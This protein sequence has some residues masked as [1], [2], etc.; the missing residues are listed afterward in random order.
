MEK[1]LRNSFYILFLGWFCSS[2]NN[3]LIGQ[4]EQVNENGLH[5]IRVDAQFITTD[6]LQQLYV[7]DQENDLVKYDA[8]GKE[9]FRYSNNT[10][11]E[12][13][14]VDATDPFNVLIYYPDFLN[15][16]TLDRTLNLTGEFN[17]QS[18][19]LLGTQAIGMSN[20]NQMWLYDENVFKLRKIDRNGEVLLESNDLGLSL[21]E[22]VSPNFV[23]ERENWV[24]LNVPSKGVLVFDNFARY[25]KMI[26]IKTEHFQIWE[27]HLVYKEGTKLFAFHLKSL[28]T[29]EIKTEAKIKPED[30][31]CLRRNLMFVDRAEGGV[32]VY[33]L[34]DIK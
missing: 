9:L 24:Y 12:L 25:N 32:E 2:C 29:K 21:G 26:N 28:L 4:S 23:V 3:Q 17:L 13:G 15:V 33:Q 34:N 16:Y 6:K 10:L 31:I 1:C 7:V 30:N 11:G 14:H 27:G 18:L 20:D 5:Q 22:S 19:G 8:E